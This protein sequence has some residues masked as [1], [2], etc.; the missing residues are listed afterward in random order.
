MLFVRFF[1]PSAP[2]PAQMRRK[3]T[4]KKSCKIDKLNAINYSMSTVSFKKYEIIFS[5]MQVY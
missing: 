4:C 2:L 3:M 5:K 1:R